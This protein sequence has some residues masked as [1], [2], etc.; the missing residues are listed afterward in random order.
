M[1]RTAVVR[2]VILA[3]LTSAYAVKSDTVSREDQDIRRQ[4]RGIA[5]IATGHAAATWR[6]A[7]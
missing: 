5:A 6:I 4:E 1:K 2:T 7:T 3:S